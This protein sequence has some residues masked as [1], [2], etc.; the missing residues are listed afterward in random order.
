MKVEAGQYRFLHFA[1]HVLL[2]NT[3]PMYSKL[4]LTQAGNLCGEDGLLK[5]REILQRR[6]NAGLVMLL[7]CQTARERR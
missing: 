2:D 3:A 5:A 7:A 4:V 6:W 1:T